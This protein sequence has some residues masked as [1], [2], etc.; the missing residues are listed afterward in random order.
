MCRVA[1]D[2][3]EVQIIER[4]RKKLEDDIAGP[5][6]LAKRLF[7][8]GL[9]LFMDIALYVLNKCQPGRYD[10]LLARAF[11]QLCERLVQNARALPRIGHDVEHAA[12]EARPVERRI[13]DR[14]C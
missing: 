2:K 11:A 12:D 14:F 10:L 8:G 13:D 1:L 7:G 3:F 5:N 6:L 4:G 9:S